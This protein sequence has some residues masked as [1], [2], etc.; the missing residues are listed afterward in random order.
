MHGNSVF[1][2]IYIRYHVFQGGT[3]KHMGCVNHHLRWLRVVFLL[4][5]ML[6]FLFVRVRIILS[7]LLLIDKKIQ[8]DSLLAAPNLNHLL[9]QVDS[10]CQLYRV[11]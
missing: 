4:D 2:M 3:S 6:L 8:N 11:P 7:L 1:P 9:P 5:R 10:S